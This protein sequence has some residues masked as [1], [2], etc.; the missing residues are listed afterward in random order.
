MTVPVFPVYEPAQELLR[1]FRDAWRHGHS[2][3]G[4]GDAK[5]RPQTGRAA[6][7]ELPAQHLGALLNANETQ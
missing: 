4:K 2:R 1:W 5:G 7:V 6:Q 3:C